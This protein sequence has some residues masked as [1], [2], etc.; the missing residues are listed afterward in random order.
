M[1]DDE[2]ETLALKHIAPHYGRFLGKNTPYQQTEQF[3]RVKALIVDLQSKLR[4]DGVQAVAELRIGVSATDQGATICIMQPHADGTITV[5]YTE[6]HPLGD[7]LGRAKFT[8]E[9]HD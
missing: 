2:I 1:T 8:K 6:T 9:S 4:A 7:S 5:V 3:R